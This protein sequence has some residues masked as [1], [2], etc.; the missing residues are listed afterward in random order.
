MKVGVTVKEV[1]GAVGD[2]GEI[3]LFNQVWDRV[4]ASVLG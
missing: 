4:G 1:V 2:G 3:S